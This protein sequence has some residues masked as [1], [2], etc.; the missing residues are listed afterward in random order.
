MGKLDYKM[1]GLIIRYSRK[2]NKMN[3]QTLADLLNTSQETIS[4]IEKGFNKIS[5]ETYLKALEYFDLSSDDGKLNELMNE[6]YHSLIHSNVYFDKLVNKYQTNHSNSYLDYLNKMF[7]EGLISLYYFDLK[8]LTLQY[9]KIN[10]LLLN[11]MRINQLTCYQ[12]KIYQIFTVVL[13]IKRKK[14]IEALDCLKDIKVDSIC[15]YYYLLISF[16]FNKY[17]QFEYC[18]MQYKK[19]VEYSKLNVL[20]SLSFLEVLRNILIRDYKQALSELNKLEKNEITEMIEFMLY[21]FLGHKEK[22]LSINSKHSMILFIKK[23][24]FNKQ[25]QGIETAYR[26]IKYQHLSYLLL[27]NQLNK[28]IQNR[29]YQL[30]KYKLYR[31]VTDCFL[32]GYK[33]G[34]FDESI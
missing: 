9:N 2:E 3:Q 25:K 13:N 16:Y 5:D 12:N 20:A 14:I 32:S 15:L 17:V 34:V 19:R 24:I 11:K 22:A 4:R 27:H 31:Q 33:G 30:R 10:K 28:F 8:E 23:Y 29:V 1:V 21:C 7:I 26:K 6:L 18:F